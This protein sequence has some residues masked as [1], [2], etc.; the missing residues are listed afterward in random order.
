MTREIFYSNKTSLTAIPKA[1]SES[2]PSY[3]LGDTTGAMRRLEIQDA[4][5]ADVSEQLLD[6]L[7]LRRADRV[8]ELGIGPG[9]LGRRILR[10]LG[11]EGVLVGVD[12][13][14]AL[15]DRAAKNLAGAG[16]ARFEPVVADIRQLGPWI[17][18]ADVVVGRT[19][20]HHLPMA[21]E[22]LGTL[23]HAV[24][25]GV[26]IGFIEPEFRAPVA[27][28]ALLI[29]QGRSELEPLR[30]WAASLIRYYQT[31]GLS[32]NIGATLALALKIAGYGDVRSSLRECPVDE[33]VIENMLL[34][35]DEVRQKYA[36]MGIMTA[37][38]IDEQQ[39]L[40]SGL[41][42]ERLPAIWDAH[43]VTCRS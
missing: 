41:S 2:S 30:A 17:E 8:V 16:N 1:M 31:N 29:A 13:T 39:R 3:V 25:P 7:E 37:A 6:A 19:V 9:G 15:L 11:A 40:L 34:Y 33:T 5:F 38:E 36:S 23:R 22:F 21:E 42:V 12:Y 43:W 10:R 18:D 24:R 14:P 28:V 32:T 26:R 27:R 4:Q 20:L 35:Y